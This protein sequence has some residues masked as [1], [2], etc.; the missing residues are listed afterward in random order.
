MIARLV[1]LERQS[2]SL[3]ELGWDNHRN[4]TEILT[5]KLP[6]IAKIT[7]VTK[8]SSTKEYRW[9]NYEYKK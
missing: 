1:V 4:S 7:T 2:K 9:L 5:V 6:R 8:D 3:S